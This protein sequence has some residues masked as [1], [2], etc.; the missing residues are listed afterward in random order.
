MIRRALQGAGAIVLLLMLTDL[1]L[2]QTDR[3]PISGK[4]V[5]G[6][7]GKQPVVDA[8]VKFTLER[9]PAGFRRTTKSRPPDGKFADEMP[10]GWVLISVFKKEEDGSIWVGK[11]RVKVDTNFGAV[12]PDVKLTQQKGEAGSMSLQESTEP[13]F[14]TLQ[15][16]LSNGSAPLSGFIAADDAVTGQEAATAVVGKDGKYSLTLEPLREYV[17][18]AASEGYD[19]KLIVLVR[20]SSLK[21]D[22]FLDR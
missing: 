13:L 14:A 9:S 20:P 21:L 1:V 2:T 16:T 15:G 19:S 5:K 18:S 3:G 4:I 11:D 7:T 10:Q 6:S 22:I 8:I 17:L 12:V